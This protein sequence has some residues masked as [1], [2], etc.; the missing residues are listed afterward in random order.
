VA[1][2]SWHFF[3]RPI[4]RLKK[5]FEYPPVTEERTTV[6]MPEPVVETL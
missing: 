3:E 2:I 5:R 6:L 1:A 4:N